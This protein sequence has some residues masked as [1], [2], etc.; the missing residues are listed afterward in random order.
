MLP[1]EDLLFCC[2]LLRWQTTNMLLFTTVPGLS[3]FGSREEAFR[4][5]LQTGRRMSDLRPASPMGPFVSGSASLAL[6]QPREAWADLQRMKE[7]AQASGDQLMLGIAWIKQFPANKQGGCGPTFTLQ[8]I[9]DVQRKAKACERLFR[10]WCPTGMAHLYHTNAK[11][12]QAMLGQAS[13]RG[14]PLN[15]PFRQRPTGCWTRVWLTWHRGSASWR[16]A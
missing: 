16:R 13:A 1:F 4:L 12:V 2:Y 3:P 15:V 14:I 8:Q 7:L 9:K 10:E 11:H 6:A 5:N